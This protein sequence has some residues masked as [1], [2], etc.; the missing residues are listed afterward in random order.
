MRGGGGGDGGDKMSA[1]CLARYDQAD[2]D[3]YRLKKLPLAS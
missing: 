2:N 1:K 3:N